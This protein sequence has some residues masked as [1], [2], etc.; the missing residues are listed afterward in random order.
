MDE[1]AERE[2]KVVM[3][4]GAPSGTGSRW[5]LVLKTIWRSLN[6]YGTAWRHPPRGA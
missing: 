2:Q 6:P 4:Q 1:A 5:K 3:S